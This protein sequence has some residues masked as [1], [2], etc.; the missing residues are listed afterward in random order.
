MPKLNKVSMFTVKADDEMF[1]TVAPWIC[2]LRAP[3]ALIVGVVPL[4]K[5]CVTET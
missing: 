5:S 4:I 3:V 2:T 1:I